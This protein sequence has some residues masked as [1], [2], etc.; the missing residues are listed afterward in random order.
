MHPEQH[1]EQ[2]S[3]FRIDVPLGV[4]GE[5]IFFLAGRALLAEVPKQS[6]SVN[7][8]H[9]QI[10]TPEPEEVISSANS[11]VRCDT[12]HKTEQVLNEAGTSMKQLIMP[13]KKDTNNSRYVVWFRN[14]GDRMKHWG[15]LGALCGAIWGLLLDSVLFAVPGIEPVVL[16][17]PLLSW[18]VAVAE[19]M[20]VFG[21]IGALAAALFSISIPKRDA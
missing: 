7:Q 9:H 21:A 15:K 19:G 3:T 8:P 11:G 14:T 10:A 2:P 5:T 17:G 1:S 13:T 4:P 12:R 16:E 6:D 18:V 20:L